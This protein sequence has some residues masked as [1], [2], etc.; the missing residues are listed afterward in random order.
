M[1]FLRS[2]I[3]SRYSVHVF[4]EYI[5]VRTAAVCYSGKLPSGVQW[6]FNNGQ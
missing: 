4:A 3:S 6:D 5:Y 2:K 1:M